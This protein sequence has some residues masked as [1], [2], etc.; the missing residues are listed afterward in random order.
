M[1]YRNPPYLHRISKTMVYILANFNV[2]SLRIR[3]RIKHT[4]GNE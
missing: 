2:L 4:T 3:L 1:E